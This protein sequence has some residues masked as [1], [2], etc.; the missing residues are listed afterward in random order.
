MK[1]WYEKM[2]NQK[3]EEYQKLLDEGKTDEAMKVFT[4]ME[5]YQKLLN[6]YS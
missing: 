1:A 5:D 6:K 2:V 3:K 4:E